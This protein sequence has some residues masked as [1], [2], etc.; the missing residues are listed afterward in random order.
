MSTEPV[1][2]QLALCRKE[3]IRLS[4]EVSRKGI[5]S[6]A[7]ETCRTTLVEQREKQWYIKSLAYQ[8]TGLALGCPLPNIRDQK[9][10]FHA[11][12]LIGK[13]VQG[14]D[15]PACPAFAHVPPESFHITIVNRS[16]Y[17]FNE[18]VSLTVD[19]RNAIQAVVA[20]LNIKRIS[21]VTSGILL[22]HTG[23]IFIKCLPLD[24]NI[25]HLRALLAES[26]P[27]LRTNIPRLVHIKIGHL[28]TPI[29]DRDLP[30][31]VSWLERLGNHIIARLD[32]TDLFTP[33]GR[34]EL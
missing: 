24:D 12:R 16:H 14:G 19:E 13:W 10:F 33:A 3:F 31:F 8:P 2:R 6:A 15:D 32:F 28:L 29:E 20:R 1:D 5:S 25:F 21:V 22:T 23:R 26:F 4:R 27:L 7:L 30:G 17:Q 9:L 34:I 11:A 18:I